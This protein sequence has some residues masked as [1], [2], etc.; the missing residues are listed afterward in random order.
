[1]TTPAVL[2]GTLSTGKQQHWAQWRPLPG[3]AV[4]GERQKSDEIMSFQSARPRSAAPV[5]T[6]SDLRSLSASRPSRVQ[7][8]G[9][10]RDF[11]YRGHRDNDALRENKNDDG[12]RAAPAAAAVAVAAVA[13]AARDQDET[14]VSS[15]ETA[16]A[17]SSAP[18]PGAHGLT[19]YKVPRGADYI[20]SYCL[21][22]TASEMAR[23]SY[24]IRR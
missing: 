18:P 17:S 13:A 11:L 16:G 20:A 6:L 14:L 5:L 23:C 7:L 19:V 12:K 21:S 24:C 4:P 15:A 9:G 22:C 10:E 2:L 1:M 8:P 3:R